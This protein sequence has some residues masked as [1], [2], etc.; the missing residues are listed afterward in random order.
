[1][2]VGCLL[3]VREKATRLPKK[4]LLDVAGKPLTQRLL[5]RLSL[6]RH[7]DQI[8]LSTSTH[9][10][11]QVLV[12]L[13]QGLGFSAFCG[14]EDD[15]LD[16]YQKTAR[17]YGLDAVVIVDGDDLFCFPEGV[18]LVAQGL[19]EGGSDCV[20]ISGL[21][22]GA[23]S[24]GLTLDALNRVLELKDEQDTEVWGG[25]FIGSKYFSSRE[26]NVEEPLLNHPEIRLT[27]DYEDDYELIKG[28]I[29]AFQGRMD[30]TSLELMDLLV[31][32]RP[33]IAQKNRKAQLK[34]E[35]HLRKS[36]PVKFK[37]LP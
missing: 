27:L 1:M 30:F 36:R 15:K 34:Y 29:E 32:R 25:Y 4:V 16:R 31:N 21:P 26:I 14:S 33:D 2:K 5:E 37:D 17:R 3:S 28:V 20:Y 9:P 24:T 19:R 23:A 12:K 13:A 6:A 11:D 10:D 8:I 7:V 22:L 35:E 18:D